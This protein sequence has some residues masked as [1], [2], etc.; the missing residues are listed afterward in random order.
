MT[1]RCRDLDAGNDKKTVRRQAIRALQAIFNK[2]VMY[3]ACIMVRDRDSAH[4]PSSR[5]GDQLLRTA[6]GIRGKEGMDVEI[7]SMKHNAG[8]FRFDEHAV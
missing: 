1:V 4:S 2:I 7:K 6:G 5:G 3:F 8:L